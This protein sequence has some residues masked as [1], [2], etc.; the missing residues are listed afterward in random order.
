MQ[1]ISAGCPVGRFF[2]RWAVILVFR[3]NQANARFWQIATESLFTKDHN[4]PS[5]ITALN[6]IDIAITW[7]ICLL[8]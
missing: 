2:A 8:N 7:D 1:E 4:I 6:F 5:N 3:N